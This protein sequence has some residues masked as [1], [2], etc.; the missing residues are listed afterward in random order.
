MDR[1]LGPMD[2]DWLKAVLA[3][4]PPRQFTVRDDGR[5]VAVC[6]VV[7]PGP[8]HPEMHLSDVCVS[9]QLRRR[10]IAARTLVAL[11]DHLAEAGAGGWTCVVDAGNV[12]AIALM[13]RDGWRRD[14][15]RDGD[16]MLGFR[17]D[18]RRA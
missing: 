7:P 6:G 12:P 1:R 8:G 13:R 15:A 9:P 2:D 11:R 5:L 17:R 10:G 3:E 16:G 4:D 18:G 14:P